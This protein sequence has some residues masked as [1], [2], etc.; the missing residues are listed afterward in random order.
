[1]EGSFF[2]WVKNIS[3]EV[4]AIFIMLGLIIFLGNKKN[5]NKVEVDYLKRNSGQKI[6]LDKNDLE[7]YQAFI[8]SELHG[9]KE[10]SNIKYH[11]LTYLN[12][13]KNVNIYLAEM[14]FSSGYL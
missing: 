7:Y 3:L 6:K 12:S 10:N 5:I 11:F 4:L 9:F 8:M 14:S 13:S 1:M 2:M